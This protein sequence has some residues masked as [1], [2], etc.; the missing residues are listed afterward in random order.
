MGTPFNMMGMMYAMSGPQR[1]GRKYYK[2]LYRAYTDETFT[3]FAE[4]PEEWAHLGTMGPVIRGTVGDTIKVV[5]K[6][7][8][9][10]RPASI[11]PHGVLYDKRSE[12]TPSTT[13]R[14]VQ[15]RTTTLCRPEA[16]TRTRGRC[17]SAPAPARTI[18]AR[19]RGSTTRTRTRS[20]T[21]TPA[22]SGRSSSR[23]GVRRTGGPAGRRR[24]TASSLTLFNIYNE[25]LSW[26]LADNIQESAG[27]PG[28]VDPTDDGF[29]ESNLMHAMSGYLYGNLPLESMTMEEGESVRWYVMAM[30]SHKD[31]HTPHWHGQTVLWNGN[32]TD[33]VELLPASMKV[34]D[35]EADNPGIWMYH[36]HVNH[37]IMAGMMARFEVE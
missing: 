36:C 4:V 25:N 32:R 24:S 13:A 5:F 16:C 35:M 20:G 1:I 9:P 14:A 23:P 12:G 8:L 28:S 27:D 6:N 34:V 31:L 3:E 21:R 30:G 29:K 33:V 10:N 37:H 19:S 17:R 7:D 15:T 2:A 22:S 18:R 11:H 26:Y